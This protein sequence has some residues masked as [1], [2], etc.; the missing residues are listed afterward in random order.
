[1]K[2]DGRSSHTAAIS[3]CF[4]VSI[5]DQMNFKKTHIFYVLLVVAIVKT[6]QS[7]LLVLNV[8]VGFWRQR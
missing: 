2:A 1:M 3:L 8:F 5:K 7:H 4:H 6:T